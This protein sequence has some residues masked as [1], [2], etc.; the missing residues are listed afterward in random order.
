MYSIALRFPR[1]GDDVGNT[2]VQFGGFIVMVTIFE[3]LAARSESKWMLSMVTL[4]LDIVTGLLL[5]GMLSLIIFLPTVSFNLWLQF[6]TSFPKNW[7]WDCDIVTDEEKAAIKARFDA[8]CFS[9]T[10]YMQSTGYTYLMVLCI[11]G[12]AFCIFHKWFFER[13]K[14]LAM[15]VVRLAI[16]IMLRALVPIMNVVLN[17]PFTDFSKQNRGNLVDGLF[18][19]Y[20]KPIVNVNAI[21]CYLRILHEYVE[22]KDADP[23]I[24]KVQTDAR[25]LKATCMALVAEEIE[26]ACTV[27]QFKQ[28]KISSKTLFSEINDI[29][30]GIEQAAYDQLP[31]GYVKEGED[32]DVGVFNFWYQFFQNTEVINQGAAETK[33]EP[34]LVFTNDSGALMSASMT[35][36]GLWAGLCVI[37][38]VIS[39]IFYVV[40]IKDGDNFFTVNFDSIFLLLGVVSL[41]GLF[42]IFATITLSPRLLSYHSVLMY[43]LAL[44]V[45]FIAIGAQLYKTN[46]GDNFFLFGGGPHDDLPRNQTY[47]WNWTHCAA[48]SPIGVSYLFAG[49]LSSRLATALINEHIICEQV[50]LK[51]TLSM[52]DR[53]SAIPDQIMGLSTCAFWHSRI[54]PL[55]SID[56][57]MDMLRIV[58]FWYET[59]VEKRFNGMLFLQNVCV[60][61]LMR[62]DRDEVLEHRHMEKDRALHKLV[63]AHHIAS[64]SSDLKGDRY[65]PGDRH[66]EFWLEVFR[67]VDSLPRSEKA[68]SG[69]CHLHSRAKL[70]EMME[71]AAAAESSK[72]DEG[73]DELAVLSAR[74]RE[75]E[76]DEENSLLR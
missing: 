53:L 71:Q 14:K 32:H 75:F 7:R 40:A 18:R 17:M 42:G 70:L 39:C 67:I 56:D 8:E 51:V 34:K 23:D 31:E 4:I 60:A 36:N 13:I 38:L 44:A 2:L 1:N 45:F 24:D 25:D 5:L 43:I 59:G 33:D 20:I 19:S 57:V 30:A 52:L 62:M 22:N 12:A 54:A 27:A 16:R 72:I 28:I 11:F 10:E 64:H 55:L 61:S 9:F 48:Y 6:Q 29:Q 41:I 65:L 47:I 68:A 66:L 74:G 73:E 63:K 69:P 26:H 3:C 49:W 15:E 46:M 50:A 76:P 58:R 21:L 35:V 37:F